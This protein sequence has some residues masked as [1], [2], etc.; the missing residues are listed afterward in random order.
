MP[1]SDYGD[2]ECCGCLFP[3]E[4]D[5]KVDLTCNECGVV[6][7]SIPVHEVEMR[8]LQMAIALGFCSEI[9]PYCKEVSTL[10][11]YDCVLAYVCRHCE[12]GVSVHRFVQ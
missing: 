12:R 6:L 3:A 9:R 4:H 1:H 7:C 11:G 10:L 5:G 2:S 8:M